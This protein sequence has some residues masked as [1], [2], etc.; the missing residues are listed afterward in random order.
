MILHVCT[1][2]TYFLASDYTFVFC[3][4]LGLIGQTI[5]TGQPH[6]QIFATLADLNARLAALGQPPFVDPIP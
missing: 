1:G 4:G 3:P 6:L 2:D 5:T